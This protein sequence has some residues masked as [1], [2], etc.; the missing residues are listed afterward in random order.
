M[1]KKYDEIVKEIKKKKK[2]FWKNIIGIV[3][4][5]LLTGL[6]ISMPRIFTSILPEILNIPE[7]ALIAILTT[8]FGGLTSIYNIVS[9]II[10]KVKI[11]KLN[12][13]LDDEIL[14][15]KYQISELTRQYNIEKEKLINHQNIKNKT[16]TIKNT[17]NLSDEYIQNEEKE[18]IKVKTR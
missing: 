3:I 10:S 17:V 15:I 14:D 12:G 5:L 16:K 1:F 4:G 7:T 9:S 11:K 8:I 6:G 2:N 18:Y 13:E